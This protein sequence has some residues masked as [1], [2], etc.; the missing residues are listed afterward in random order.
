MAVL[1]ALVGAWVTSNVHN[2]KL[3]IW[4]MGATAIFIAIYSAQKMYTMQP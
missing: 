2:F 4:S 3:S 1:A